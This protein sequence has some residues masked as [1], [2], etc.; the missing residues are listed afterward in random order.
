MKAKVKKTV[1]QKAAIPQAAATGGSVPGSKVGSVDW[2]PTDR[3]WLAGP[4]HDS[5]DML[6]IGFT[7][8]MPEVMVASTEQKFAFRF[9]DFGELAV[10]LMFQKHLTGDDSLGDPVLMKV[11]HVSAYSSLDGK[12]HVQYVVFEDDENEDRFVSL[13]ALQF[14]NAVNWW[15]SQLRRLLGIDA[16][17]KHASLLDAIKFQIALDPDLFKTHMAEVAQLDPADSPINYTTLSMHGRDGSM[18]QYDPWKGVIQDG[19]KNAKPTTVSSQD[20]QK[21]KLRAKMKARKGG[22]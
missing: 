8:T 14:V 10:R 20:V 19:K 9:Q 4:D 1:A 18:W 5:S 3:H 2:R 13:S 7:K 12:G 6:F 22:R 16:W 17:K 11:A 21:P 15:V